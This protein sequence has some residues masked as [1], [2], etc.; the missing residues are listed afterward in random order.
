M[1]IREFV[2][3]LPG[4]TDA[5][6]CMSRLSRPRV[7]DDGRVLRPEVAMFGDQVAEALAR[8]LGTG[9]VGVYF[10]GSVALGGY[11]PGESDID[12]AGVSSAGLTDPQRQ[13]VASAVVEVSA[14]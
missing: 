8:S 9:L 4:R 1:R 10:V 12:I 7:P 13:S 5:R 3:P 14:A 2:V 6:S 11:V